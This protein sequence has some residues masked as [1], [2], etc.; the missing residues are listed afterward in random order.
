MSNVDEL[1][2]LFCLLY[3]AGYQAGHHDT[4][5]GG[6]CEVHDSDRE[7]YHEDEVR[8]LLVDE[9]VGDDSYPHWHSM[10][11]AEKDESI[12]KAV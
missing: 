3:N 1:I 6:F 2:P 11:D 12:R 4:V 9:S 7:T 5:E 8:E 10:S